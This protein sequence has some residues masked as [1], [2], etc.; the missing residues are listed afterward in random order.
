ME[1]ITYT[2]EDLKR[3][4]PAKVAEIAAAA[5][6]W[7]EFVLRDLAKIDEDERVPVTKK[8]GSRDTV[9][10]KIKPCNLLAKTYSGI[11]D[12]CR[13]EVGEKT[14]QDFGEFVCGMPAEVKHALAAAGM[15]AETYMTYTRSEEGKKAIAVLPEDRKQKFSPEAATQ[16][17]KQIKQAMAYC[18]YTAKKHLPNDMQPF[19][20]LK[21]TPP[22][23]AMFYSAYRS[24]TRLG[25]RPTEDNTG[26]GLSFGAYDRCWMHGI[27]L[28]EKS[29]GRHA[30]AVTR[31]ELRTR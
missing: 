30:G 14:E 24:T 16:F 18:A 13:Q 6:E 2:V 29:V 31:G 26:V 4:T 25:N 15:L 7:S 22:A 12:F 17:I 10:E 21:T 9:G 23:K 5:G 20:I 8:Y 1:S 28:S 19:L 27:A 11:I 3:I